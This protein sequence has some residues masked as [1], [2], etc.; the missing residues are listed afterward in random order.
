MI[1]G[2]VHLFAA[3]ESR[4]EAAGSGECAIM[5]ILMAGSAQGLAG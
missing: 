1:M 3:G 2:L 5:I 4:R